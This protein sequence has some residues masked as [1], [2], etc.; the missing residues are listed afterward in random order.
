[1]S[2]EIE[3]PKTIISIISQIKVRIE[4]SKGKDFK[5]TLEACLDTIEVLGSLRGNSDYLV[6]EI[7]QI[8]N[9]INK[10]EKSDFTGLYDYQQKLLT[11][12]Q[13]IEREFSNIELSK[14]IVNGNGI[15]IERTNSVNSKKQYG[16]LIA[17]SLSIGALI[18][19]TT[20]STYRNSGIYA[21]VSTLLMGLVAGSISKVLK[22][23]FFNSHSSSLLKYSYQFKIASLTFF[24]SGLSFL[25]R[26]LLNN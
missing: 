12:L 20:F 25:T 8:I 19:D 3:E 7:G 1:M 4:K 5:N 10:A 2:L 15:S 14:E 9:G 18:L 24:I 26:T 11:I 22:D 17:L 16:V 23:H 13:V 6:I 21:S